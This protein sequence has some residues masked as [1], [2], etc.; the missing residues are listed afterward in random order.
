MNIGK[1]HVLIVHF[2]IALACAAVLAE[3]LR[4]A[5]REDWLSHCGLYCLT[6]AAVSAL[7]VV[8]TGL[9]A[10]QSQEFVGDYASIVTRHQW[11][12]IASFALALAAAAVRLSHP[13][14]LERWWRI[15]YWVLLAL[16][17]AGIAVTG[18]A[19]GMLVHGRNYFSF[20]S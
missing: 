12:G 16:L 10:A 17:M 1:L 8:I 2:P 9:V 15:A 19:G 18:H 4:L 20:S 7:P 5:F 3:L 13:D 11:A 6:L 14:R